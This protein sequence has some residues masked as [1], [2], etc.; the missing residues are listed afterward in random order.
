MEYLLKRSYPHA[1]FMACLLLFM[2]GACKEKKPGSANATQEIVDSPSEMDD[3]AAGII[4]DAVKFA[5]QNKGK[6][7]DTVKLSRAG[8]LQFY[9][10]KNDFEP[11][12]SH[13][14]SWLPQADSLYHFIENARE[15]GLFPEDYHFRHLRSIRN[16][17]S[18]D[19]AVA[20]KNAVL[21][22]KADVM[23]TDAFMLITDHLHNGRLMRDSMS[24][25]T[26]SN[27]AESFY[28]DAMKTVAKEKGVLNVFHK[29]EPTHR[30]YQ[31]LRRGIKDFL[32]TSDL[33]HFTYVVYPYKD[34]LSFVKT[35]AKRLTEAGYL[36]NGGKTPDSS[37]LASAI[38]KYQNAKGLK[39]D[40]R[41]GDAVVK[42][43]NN[44]DLNKFV[45]IA[46]TLDRY[47]QLPDKMPETFVWVNL[48]GFNL[49]VW[50][51]DTLAVTSDVIVGKP[52]TRTPVITSA[53]ENIVLHPTW[54]V[55]YSIASKEILPSVQRNPGYLARRGF[56]V[57]DSRGRVVDPYSI[58]WSKY[59]R[60]S[61]PYKF[62]QNN[63]A[64][65]ALGEI[66]FN[67]DNPHAVY[68][69]DT[70][71]RYMFSRTNKSL[72][73]G[74]VRV[75]DWELLAKFLIRK[76]NPYI[77]VYETYSRDSIGQK[78]DTIRL[79]KTVLVDSFMV[80]A[81]SLKPI[82]AK[83][84]STNTVIMPKKVPIFIR[85]FTCAGKNGKVV[86]YDDIYAEDKV[87]RDKY[88][89]DK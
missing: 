41:F 11:Q 17:I 72:S 68:L 1:V 48:P 36:D 10:G 62:R 13:K 9:Y 8:L 70:N 84:K 81:D 15:Y 12:W 77:P 69:H 56:K 87:L 31:E 7:D 30:G 35:L 43:L 53:I 16:K 21:W 25:R 22:A 78:G 64:G 46:I 73:H 80:Q 63:G 32:S 89:A 24:L 14:E 86:F 85:Y 66:K 76:T 49:E 3:R 65:N 67:F 61:L 38:K 54:T 18:T 45:R 57:L 47:K 74:C 23:M 55:P 88:F 83:R 82:M 27:L 2:M 34:S 28:G 42:S 29:M 26:D 71:Q 4:E 52:S 60:S 58:N 19:P 20:K 33:R 5:M 59:S 40:G 37:S 44:T 50:D 6:V 51:H 75:K 39:A 79:S